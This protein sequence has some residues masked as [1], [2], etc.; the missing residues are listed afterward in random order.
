MLFRSKLHKSIGAT[1]IYVTH[2]QT[3]AMTMADRIVV[4]NNGYIQQVGEPEEIYEHPA[5][6]F[7][8]SFLGSP[9]INFVKGTYDDGYFV[10]KTGKRIKMSDMQ[11]S[12]LENYKGKELIFGIRPEDIYVEDI[13]KETYPSTVSTFKI[14]V[15][16]MLGHEY[17]LYGNIEGNDFT[18]RTSLRVMAKEKSELEVAFDLSKCHVFDCDTEKSIF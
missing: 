2:D 14:D 5:N 1:T 18:M 7:V 16:E 11:T 15:T 12:L 8:A 9:Q 4:M 6:L 17:I 13:V 10:F 3:E